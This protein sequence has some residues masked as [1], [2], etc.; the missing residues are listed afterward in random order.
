MLLELQE[1]QPKISQDSKNRSLASEEND[2][3]SLE[4]HWEVTWEETFCLHEAQKL[5][6]DHSLRD[7]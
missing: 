2:R 3:S 1:T 4:D 6:Q 7:F 5:R